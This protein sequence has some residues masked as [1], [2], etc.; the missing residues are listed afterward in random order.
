MEYVYAAFAFLAGIGAFMLGVNFLS[1][2]IKKLASNG[3]RTLFNKTA[4]NRIVSLGIGVLVTALVQSS[5]L[6][7]VMVVGFVN[8]GMMTLFQATAVIMGANIGTTVTAQIAALQ[9]FSLGKIAMGLAGIGVFVTLFTKR[10]RTKSVGNILVGFG[11]IFLGL[12]TMVES[13]GIIAESEA[14]VALLSTLQN[15][16]LLFLIG[17]ALT[18]LIHNSAAIATILISMVAAGI[19]IG[20]G[21]NAIL[22]VV[23]GSNVGT[24]VTAMMSS[25]G[26]NTNAKRASLIHLLFNVVGSLIF[27]IVLLFWNGFMDTWAILFPNPSTQIAMFHT[28]FNTL[29]ALL[30]LPFTGV[31]VK[32]SEALIRDKSGKEQKVSYLDERFLSTPAVALSVAYQ[33]VARMTDDAVGSLKT[34]LD[35]FIAKSDVETE[36]VGETLTD[37]N[38]ASRAV[39]DYLVKVSAEDVGLQNE[40]KINAIYSNLSDIA[41]VAELADNITKY[42]RKEIDDNLVFSD[43]VKEQLIFMFG[44]IQTM[45]SLAK[46]CILTGDDT[47]IKEVE[48]TESRIDEMRRTLISDHMDRLKKGECRAENSSVFI[49]LV[50]NLERAGDHLDYVA[51][52]IAEKE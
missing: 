38:Q 7:T 4:K 13:M 16:F 14:V 2:N 51:H 8:S 47:V 9:S 23:L 41:R 24:C 33:E 36:A 39:T 50:C 42:T 29:C 43:K 37:I 22:F 49:N 27:F 40:A 34:A 30:F 5:T 11:L 35:G 19:Q 44:E 10:E 28:V 17:A 20:G 32:I 15:P 31:F 48:E 52:S 46:T 25:V 18:A 26:A 45:S 21:G 12:Q 1:D 3:I 6:T